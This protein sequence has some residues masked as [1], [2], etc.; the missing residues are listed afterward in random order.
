MSVCFGQNPDMSKRGWILAGAV[1][2]VLISLLYWCKMRTREPSYHGKPLTFWLRQYAVAEAGLNPNSANEAK[3]AVHA[4]G[5]NAIPRCLELMR[6]RDSRWRKK[7]IPLTPPWWRGWMARDLA[8]QYRR[9]GS[10]GIAILGPEAK[11]AVP[12]LVAQTR[13]SDADVRY[14]AVYALRCIGPGAA[15]ALPRMIECLN[16]P[17]FT[18]R[19][20]AILAL[21]TFQ[22]APEAVIP[23]LIRV[24]EATTNDAILRSD[25]MAS[26]ACFEGRAK[27]AG[28]SVSR[29]LND[30]EPSAR[31]VA[32]N[33]L[34]RIDPEAARKMGISTEGR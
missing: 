23:L 24:L 4:I 28:P 15:E 21:G 26:L 10:D 33:V 34:R 16:D 9:W 6:M 12:A 11:A 19:D 30:S 18:V 3:S 22:R 31:E 5:T 14:V 2:A 27:S 32:T 20:D 1:V 7:L 13:D 8:A 17:E 25:A 29:F